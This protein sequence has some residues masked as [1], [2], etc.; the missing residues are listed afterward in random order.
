M[1]VDKPASL[2]S[3]RGFM[4]SSDIRCKTR[5]S[6]TAAVVRPSARAKASFSERLFICWGRCH[7]DAQRIWELRLQRRQYAFQIACKLRHWDV[8]GIPRARVIVGAVTPALPESA[9]VPL[10]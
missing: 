6:E 9:S 7:Q 3:P 1:H 2:I 10:V 4:A 5:V 8:Q